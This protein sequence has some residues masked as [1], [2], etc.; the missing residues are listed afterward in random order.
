I[1]AKALEY[2][3][4]AKTKEGTEKE[5]LITKAKEEENKANEKHL[6]AAEVLKDDNKSLFDTNNE[7]IETLKK[8]GKASETDISEVNKLQEAANTAYKQA[9]NMRQEANSLPNIGAKLGNLG[10]AEEKE[11]EALDKQKQALYILQKTNPNAVLKTAVTSAGGA[12]PAANTGTLNLDPQ[13]ESVNAGLNDLANLKLSAYQ[14]LYEANKAELDALVSNL[15]SNLTTIDKTPSLK[16]EFIAGNNKITKSETQ[17]QASD[18]ATNNNTKLN[19]LINA[20]K[21]QVEAINQLT[22]L[23]KKLNQAIAKNNPENNNTGNKGNETVNTNTTAAN[24]NTTSVNSNTETLNTNTVAVNTN[25]ESP[26]TNTTAVNGNTESANTNTEVA[27][28]NTEAANTNTTVANSNTEAAN[29]NTTAANTE[30]N[31][32]ESIASKTVDVAE[33]AKKDTSVAQVVNYFET[34]KAA[35]KNQGA[36]QLVNN[37]LTEL[38]KVDADNKAVDAE[39][40]SAIGTNTSSTETPFQLKTK[41]ESLLVEAEDLGVKSFYFKKAANEK[42]GSEKDSLL[43]QAKEL[44]DQAIN[45]KLEAVKL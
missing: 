4:E 22:A 15:R 44:D 39:I 27:N 29:T 1:M 12:N 14:K 33:L 8:E 21:I 30:T 41:A 38:K 19:D 20:T 11:A 9:V 42:S 3:N 5:T 2:R 32:T 40:K 43:A 18:A 10:N 36:S 45:K 25:T 34:N 7:N 28:T 13:L 6:Q 26:N 16:S 31:N 17:K 23:E 37:S 24:T 35:L